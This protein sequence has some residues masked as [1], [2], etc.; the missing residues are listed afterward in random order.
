VLHEMGPLVQANGQKQ[1]V[2]KYMSTHVLVKEGG[3]WMETAV[4]HTV[5]Q[6]AAAPSSDHQ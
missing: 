6:P 1:P 2:Q 3:R 4:Q 5:V